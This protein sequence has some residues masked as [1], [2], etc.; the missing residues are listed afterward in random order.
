MTSTAQIPSRRR[1]FSLC[2]ATAAGAALWRLGLSPA[3]AS[4]APAP[5]RLTDAEWRKRLPPQAYAVLRQASTEYPFTSP[6]NSEHRHG[7][8]VCAGCAL[9]LFASAT[10]FDSGTGWPSFSDH[11]PGAIGER[12]D[13]SLL[14][15][16]TEVHCARCGGH[17][18]HVFEDGPQPT[19]LRYCMNGV[20]MRFRAA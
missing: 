17:L 11:L 16:R 19:G 7:T 6:L 15:V 1:F 3:P 8:F 18:G 13:R 9:P 4:A 5:Y 2:T 12:V 10:K 20:A 14:E